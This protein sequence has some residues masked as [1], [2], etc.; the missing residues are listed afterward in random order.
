MDAP[1][2][3]RLPRPSPE[4][5]AKAIADPGTPWTTWFYESALKIYIPLGFFIVDTWIAGYWVE[6]GLYLALLPSL[7]AALYLEYLAFSYLWYRP[8]TD[9]SAS[10]RSEFRPHWLRPVEFGRWTPE[11][12]RVR[13]GLSPY[14]GGAGPQGPD[15]AE[16]F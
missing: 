1:N 2:P 16:F 14:P 4:D 12:Q 9:A 3:L 5:R 13:A 15:P 7:G 11:G 10:V 6:N 8:R